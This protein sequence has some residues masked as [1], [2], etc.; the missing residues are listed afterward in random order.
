[1]IVVG[2]HGRGTLARL[3][4]GSVMAHLTQIADRPVLVCKLHGWRR[5]RGAGRRRMNWSRSDISALLIAP[6]V[7]RRPDA[8]DADV[9]GA[10]G[11]AGAGHLVAGQRDG[12]HDAARGRARAARQPD[13][14]ARLH[15]LSRLVRYTVWV[16]G[17]IVV[18]NYVGIDLT[19]VALVGGA[20]A[21][22]LGFGL[23]NI[24]SQLHQRHHHPARRHAARGRLR[25]PASPACAATCA[26][27]R[28]AT[29]A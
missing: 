14:V 22:G 7:Q 3:V 15:L 5:R 4:L 9:A 1:M 28:C 21:F 19:S 13:H 12:A 27:S 6:A 24:F 8:G 18:L 16:L 29:R 10:D 20:V 17:T 26:R 23:Q 11:G 25:R 2:S